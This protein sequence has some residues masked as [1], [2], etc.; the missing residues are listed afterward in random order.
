[1]RNESEQVCHWSGVDCQE[2]NTSEIY[3]LLCK[4]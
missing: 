1:M 2:K 4:Y 3:I